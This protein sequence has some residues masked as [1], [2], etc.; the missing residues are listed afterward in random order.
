MRI[1]YL[2]NDGSLT[3]SICRP[4]S[5]ASL[6]L[7]DEEL[8]LIRD[9]PE[10]EKGQRKSYEAYCKYNELVRKFVAMNKAAELAGIPVEY[11]E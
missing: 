4:A 8:S 10:D 2:E 11:E 9:F 6:K 1:P 5:L 3:Y 7:S